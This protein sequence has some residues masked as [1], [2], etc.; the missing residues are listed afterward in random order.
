MEFVRLKRHIHDYEKVYVNPKTQTLELGGL[1][2]KSIVNAIGLEKLVNLHRL[3]VQGDRLTKIEGL[4]KLRNLRELFL[5]SNEISSIEN[6]SDFN[7]CPF[8][9]IRNINSSNSIP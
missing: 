4:E 9:K 5:G 1:R 3:E 7:S 2:L 6:P 8:F